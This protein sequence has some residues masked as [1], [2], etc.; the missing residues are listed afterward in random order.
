MKRRQEEEKEV[1][2][3]PPGTGCWSCPSS[4][5]H[6]PHSPGGCGVC[7]VVVVDDSVSGVATVL[8]RG[9]SSWT[10]KCVSGPCFLPAA[11]AYPWQKTTVEGGLVL[12]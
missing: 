12:S 7:C 11:R 5:C 1:M 3:T 6:R 8:R 10:K 9:C 2:K 4:C